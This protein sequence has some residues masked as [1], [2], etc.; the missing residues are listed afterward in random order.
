MGLV[1]FGIGSLIGQILFF[2]AVLFVYAVTEQSQAAVVADG[3]SP[4]DAIL[5]AWKLVNENLRL[6]VTVTPVLYFGLSWISGV[7]MALVMLPVFLAAL[8]KFTTA[9]SNPSLT[10]VAI[11]CFVVFLPVYLFLQAGALLY[12]KSAFMLTYLRLTRSPKLQPLLTE[13][14][15]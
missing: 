10:W 8:S 9:F 4:T 6:F 1:T 5:H 11:I 3:M 7:A 14:T 2:P 15:S 13:A 12:T